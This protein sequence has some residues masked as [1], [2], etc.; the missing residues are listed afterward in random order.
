[1]RKSDSPNNI[2]ELM[3]IVLGGEFFKLRQIPAR[4][5]P[6]VPKKFDVMDKTIEHVWWPPF[7]GFFLYILLILPMITLAAKKI[8]EYYKSQVGKNRQLEK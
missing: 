4:F 5:V 1:V 6:V 3:L 8:F 7:G 2:D